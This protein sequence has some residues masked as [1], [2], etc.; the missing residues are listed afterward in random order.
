M[1]IP[2]KV[3]NLVWAYSFTRCAFPDCRIELVSKK[4]KDNPKTIGEI[5]HICASKKGGPRFDPNLSKKDRDSY[6]NLILLCPNHHTIIDKES[7]IY[8]VDK[9]KKMKEEHE[10]WGNESLNKGVME[11]NFSQL[12]TITNAII[13]STQSLNSK[14]I[15]NTLLALDKKIKKNE[16]SE[17]IKQ[18]ISMGLLKVNEVTDFL[19]D[20]TKRIPNFTEKLKKGLID[21]YNELIRNDLKGDELFIKMHEFSSLN[22]TDFD[23]L[24]VGLT[25]LVYFFERC[26]VFEK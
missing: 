8:T 14:N 1:S 22:K 9:L 7:S 26:E 12:E 3:K 5:A 24:S 11:V 15:D 13:A 23:T 19:N 10:K 17:K 21:K 4:E 25:V 20:I 16:L 18:N 2:Q 6:K